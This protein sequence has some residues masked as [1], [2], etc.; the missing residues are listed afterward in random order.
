MRDGGNL[1]IAALEQRLPG[2]R[3]WYGPCRYTSARINTRG[4]FEQRYGR[5]EAHIEL[6][7]RQGLWPA[8]WILGSNFGAVRWPICVEIDI[9]EHLGREPRTVHGTIHGPDYSGGAGIGKPY[10][11]ADFADQFHVFALEWEPGALRWY[12]D[13]VHYQTRTPAD[14][15]EDARWV[16]DQ[17]FFMILNLAVGGGWGS[18]R[19]PQRMLVD[20]VRVYERVDSR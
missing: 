17:P 4:K 8:F 14:L 6:P 20:Y 9:M 2:A 3:C 19:F 5:F 18:A 13:G 1:A 11:P 10:T 16:F 12:V 15:P 7:R